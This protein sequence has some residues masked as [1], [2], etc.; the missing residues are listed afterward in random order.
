MVPGLHFC[1]HRV[2]LSLFTGF[3]SFAVIECEGEWLEDSQE[4]E[5]TRNRRTA[6]S[7]SMRTRGLYVLR[8]TNAWA[9]RPGHSSP[10]S[11]GG[12]GFEAFWWSTV[13]PLEGFPRGF[14]NVW[15]DSS[16]A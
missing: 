16:L 11:G 8:L 4:Q 9:A 1:G 7:T 2:K 6:A 13:H 15:V 14:G 12:D 5:K 10:Q 3:M